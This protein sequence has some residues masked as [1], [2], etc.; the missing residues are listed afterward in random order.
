M[1]RI[2]Y[3]FRLHFYLTLYSLDINNLVL[4]NN[5]YNFYY[6]YKFPTMVVRDIKDSNVIFVNNL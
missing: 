1:L 5:K 6:V 2:F 4:L 3:D